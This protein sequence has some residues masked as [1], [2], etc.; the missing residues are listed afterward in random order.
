MT[1][2]KK[3]VA[4]ATAMGHIRFYLDKRDAALYG[5]I[6]LEQPLSPVLADEWK[7]KTLKEILEI[8]S[9]LKTTHA[10]W[11]KNDQSCHAFGKPCTYLHDCEFGFESV[12]IS[13]S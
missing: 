12:Q 7:E 13:T 1:K 11:P 2:T 6:Y 3:K 9:M 5:P 10:S 8:E 4:G